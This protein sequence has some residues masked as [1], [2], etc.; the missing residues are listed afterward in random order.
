MFAGCL[1]SCSMCMCTVK[2]DCADDDDG[3]DDKA[4]M[5]RLLR[6]NVT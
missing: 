5:R 1:L 4:V 6:L 3:G 2:D